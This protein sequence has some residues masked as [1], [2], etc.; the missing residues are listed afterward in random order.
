LLLLLLLLH[1]D[2]LLEIV[3]I[4]NDVGVKQGAADVVELA[5]QAV[6]IIVQPRLE[7]FIDGGK[8]QFRPQ[9]ARQLFRVV[10]ELAIRHAG[11]L[12]ERVVEFV[13]AKPD[14]TRKIL[15]QQ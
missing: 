4:L 9:P 8:L 10:A 3:E 6:E 7:D 5:L 1:H 11:D 12:A 13:H 15:V 2:F 14:G